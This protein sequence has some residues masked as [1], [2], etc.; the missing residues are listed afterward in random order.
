MFPGHAGIVRESGAV[1]GS[2]GLVGA[3]VLFWGWQTGLWLFALPIAALLESA[4]FVTWRWDFSHAD[5]RRVADLSRLVL[6]GMAVYLGAVRGPAPTVLGLIQWFPLAVLPLV[7]CQAYGARPTVDPRT[8]FL[9]LRRRPPG[10]DPPLDVGYP[11]LALCVAGASAANVRSAGFY[12]GLCVLL[13]WALWPLRSRAVLWPAWGALLAVAAGLGYAGHVGLHAFQGV[14]EAAVTEWVLD[15][16]GWDRDPFRSHT[17]LGSIGRLKLSDR[18]L[19]RVDTGGPLPAPLLLHE[20][21]YDVYNMSVWGATAAE[22]GPVPPARDRRTWSLQPGA[23]PTGRVTVSAYLRR[24]RGMVP[25][26]DGTVRVEDLLALQMKRNRLGA[27]KVEESLGLVTY[28]AGVAPGR[29]LGAPP[30]ETDFQLPKQEAPLLERIAGELGLRDRSSRDAVTAV[31]QYFGGVFRYSTDLEAPIGRRTALEDFLLR[32]RTGHCEYFGTATVLLLRAGGIP[33]RYAV[34]YAVSEWSPHEERYLVRA[35]HAHSWAQAWVDGAWRDVD[36]TPPV[37]A[38]AEASSAALWEPLAD[39]ASWAVFVFSRW[40]WSEQET[41][42]VEYLEWLLVPLGGFLAWRLYSRRRVARAPGRRAAPAGPGPAR[43][44]GDSELYLIE[45]RLA[46]RGLGRRPWEP[47]GAWLG[48]LRAAPV[49]GVPPE[50]L[51]ALEALVRLHYRYRF[52]PDGLA[53]AER[54]T[55]RAG[56]HAWL[57]RAFERRA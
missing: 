47:V 2:P 52:D 4:R 23:A 17:A 35:R 37:W 29:P 8:F 53:P 11:Y 51:A 33:A 7:V 21:S 49:A 56:A 26:P 15:Y 50:V 9:V 39:L 27:V 20:A 34:G 41:A 25:L 30:V 55:L 43:P 54:E 32:T 16:V 48:R 13:A 1:S 14:V 19:L 42:Y 36:T 12:V 10:S 45:A 18:I 28:T 3:A 22:F 46:A 24:G 5:T 31:R 6:V 44:G 57:T 40:R 38:T